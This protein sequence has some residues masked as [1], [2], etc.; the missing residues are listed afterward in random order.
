MKQICNLIFCRKH[1]PFFLFT[2]ITFGAFFP[3][4][5]NDFINWDDPGYI[6]ENS[7]IRSISLDRIAH[8]FSSFQCSNYNPLHRV[9]YMIDYALWGLNYKGFLLT[10]L[11]LHLGSGFLVWIIFLALS[12][13]RFIAGLCAVVFLVHPTRCESVVWL[14]ERKDVLS[15]FL[16][17]LSLW[18]FLKWLEPH[19]KSTSKKESGRSSTKVTFYLASMLLFL[20]ALCAKSQLV[21]LP[22]VFLALALYYHKKVKHMLV[23]LA[24]FW[25]LSAVFSV[26]TVFAHSNGST[27]Q[28]AKSSLGGINLGR[29]YATL[30]AYF[31]KMVL[32]VDLSPV[33]EYATT[34]AFDI[35]RVLPG[36]IMLAACIIAMAV[37]LK[38]KRIIFAGASWFFA[39][40]LPVSGIIPNIIFTADRYL[41]LSML[42]PAWITG[43]VLRRHIHQRRARNGILAFA[44]VLFAFMTARYSTVWRDTET[45]WKHVLKRHPDSFVAHGTLGH[46][47]FEQ[48]DFTKAKA[49]FKQDLNNPPFASTSY[50]GL[51]RIYG[52]EGKSDLAFTLFEQFLRS[53]GRSSRSII[54]YASFLN[55][56]GRHQ[57]ALALLNEA[58]SQRSALFHQTLSDVYFH[59][60]NYKKA[61]YE[62]A[63][64]LRHTPYSA[65]N[66]HQMAVI[67]TQC[68]NDRQAVLCFQKA[69]KHDP[70]LQISYEALAHLLF[71][72]KQYRE[73]IAC[74][75]RAPVKTAYSRHLLS[76]CSNQASRINAGMKKTPSPLLHNQLLSEQPIPPHS[77]KN[78]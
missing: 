77:R 4:F 32:P 47:Y 74:L 67:E 12:R 23:A 20:L 29:A 78:Q 42:G 69:I 30:S 40:L 28:A 8:C 75:Q 35:W 13:N 21:T 26:I 25:A 46:Y 10:N 36:F 57:E 51:A 24:P 2:V 56:N 41:Y 65:V 16:G 71:Q 19:G 22:L 45:F 53:T 72:R 31:K 3:A 52:K 55:Q 54:S 70:G 60:G 33:D 37:S 50:P 17:L 39:L 1:V 62:R 44:A 48:G 76:R 64:C 27:G 73:A 7:V 63:W 9:S 14:S 66:W 68:R 61:R 58:P 6:T 18:C 11:L 43:E 38:R 49:L 34:I 59:L 15:V 5:D